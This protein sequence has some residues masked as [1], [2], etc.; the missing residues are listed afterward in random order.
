MILFTKSH[1]CLA[2]LAL[3]CSILN[4]EALAQW[5]SGLGSPAQQSIPV[6]I[7][8]MDRRDYQGRY[9]AEIGLPGSFGST[10]QF[11]DRPA[12]PAQP[13][14]AVIKVDPA[15]RTLSVLQSSQVI[16]NPLPGTFDDGMPRTMW[17][18]DAVLYKLDPHGAC[19]LNRQG[20]SVRACQ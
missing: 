10:D 13:A 16:A 19:T 9:Q 3:V 2:G 6:T 4:S 7:N 20:A 12:A 1:R 11:P 18:A 5:G 15:V 8:P 17:S 14:S